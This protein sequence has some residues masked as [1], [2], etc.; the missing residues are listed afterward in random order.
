LKTF[1]DEIVSS[2]VDKLNVAKHFYE[3]LYSASDTDTILQEHFL[4]LLPNVIAIEQ[5]MTL[6]SILTKA[7]IHNTINEM[8]NCKAPGPVL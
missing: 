5:N 2:P 3:S 6:G 8:K 4:Q 1:N 7:E